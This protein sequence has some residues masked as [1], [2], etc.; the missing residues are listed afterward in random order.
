M[1]QRINPKN[2]KTSL[3]IYKNDNIY[4]HLNMKNCGGIKRDITKMINNNN[5]TYILIYLIKY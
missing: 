2:D 1:R 3:K 5:Y 4:Y